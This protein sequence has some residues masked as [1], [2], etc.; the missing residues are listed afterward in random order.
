MEHA[1]KSFV[2]IIGIILIA[3]VFA[4]PFS[5]SA[6]ALTTVKDAID[7]PTTGSAS[8]HDISFR[9]PTGVDAPTDTM[10][11]SFGSFS[12]SSIVAGDIG[13]TYGATGVENTATIA[14]APGVGVWGAVIAGSTLTL[15]AP[16]DAAPGLI[17]PNAFIH[18]L[19]GTN[20]SGGTHQIVNP[21]PA[22][23]VQV[24]I[25]GAFGDTGAFGTAIVDS[26]VVT[27][28]ASYS[29]T[30]PGGHHGDT[31][32]PFIYNV[33]ATSTSNTSERITWLTDENANSAVS[34]GQGAIASGTVNGSAYVI[35]HAIDIT[36]LIACQTYNYQ[37][38]SSDVYGNEGVSIVYTFQTPCDHTPPVITNPHAENI[39]DGSVL[40]IWSTNEP[41]TSIVEYGTTPA[42]GATGTVDG[43]VTSHAVPIAG[44]APD[45]TY[46]YRVIS[47][48]A[49]GNTSVTEDLTFTTGPDVTPPTNVS[50]IATPGDTI[51]TL[52]WNHPPEADTAGV[53]IVRRT[54]RIPTGPNDGIVIYDGN[55]TNMVDTG[56]TNGV[57]YYYGAFA[58]DTHG[59]YSSGAIASAVPNGPIIPP[60]HPPTSTPP[61]Y[62]PTTTPPTYPPTYPPIGPATTTPPVQPQTPTP[63]ATIEFT[64]YGAG[65]HLPLGTDADGRIGVRGNASITIRVPR[66]A[67]NGTATNVI[68]FVGVFA[69]QLAYDPPLDAYATTFSVSPGQAYSIKVQAVFTDGRI[70]RKDGVIMAYGDGHV[71]ER[72]I[73]GIGTIPVPGASI[74]LYREMLGTWVPWNGAEYGEQNP[75]LT[76]SAGGFVFEVPSGNY[77]AEVSKDGFE[78][79]K[80]DPI[81]V[82]TNIFHPFIQ[83]IRL[84]QIVPT[85]QMGIIE[86][87]TQQAKYF[88]DSMAYR[89][90]KLEE[91]LQ[92][93]AV[94]DVNERIFGPAIVAIALA[95]LAPSAF[96]LLSLLQYLFTQPILLFRRRR[97]RAYGVVYNSLTKLPIDLAIVRL[98]DA[99]SHRVV[100]TCITDKQGRYFFHVPNGTYLLEVVKPEYEYPSKFIQGKNEDAGYSDLHSGGI[101][102]LKEDA[103]IAL[104]VPIDPIARTQTPRRIRFT[105]I[106]KTIRHT[107]GFSGVIVSIICF[108]ISPTI[109]MALFVLMQIAIYRMFKRLVIPM[110]AKKWGTIIDVDT[111]EPVSRAVV[112]LYDTDTDQI[113]AVKVTNRTGSYGFL[114]G[115]NVYRMT[116]EAENYHPEEA[117]FD[118]RKS[119][120]LVVRKQV[121]LKR[122]DSLSTLYTH[123]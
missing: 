23:Q 58:Y 29:A 4:F 15:T 14:G 65:G 76:D 34:Y 54:D 71:V 32:P 51:I 68:A 55:G 5:T 47:T 61:T 67:M 70:A 37:I 1:S 64:L 122:T 19:I 6:A 35:S 97:K 114:V 13:M 85:K 21:S 69:F 77:Y 120:D 96:Q 18:I 107:I 100:Q 31:S 86:T 92:G 49:S 42:Y 10:T 98:L 25:A 93:K 91:F 83:L 108:A 57:T 111:S 43:L 82:D 3:I 27:V 38:R 78:T 87:I 63:G 24:S 99:T 33:Q 119:T 90:K 89:I 2:R 81:Y 84:P 115:K 28:T 73:F 118:F 105:R 16:T 75:K 123:K 30:T 39:T 94:Q 74:L 44:L 12:L 112:R 52:T 41:A 113:V 62:P 117:T 66:N 50:L 48:D 36:G 106:G 95:N 80:T 101:I 22:G 45:T 72:P 79:F 110:P 7:V 109:P 40:I 103:I 56:L 11:V 17:S 60:V 88:F 26:N 59:N 53:R 9:T 20:V 104:N 102:E 121:G 8:N 46:H 116:V